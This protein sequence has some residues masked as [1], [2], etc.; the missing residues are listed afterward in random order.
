MFIYLVS[1]FGLMSAVLL[2]DDLKSLSG[3]EQPKQNEPSP[4]PELPPLPT[5]GDDKVIISQGRGL[6]LVGD[7]SN[8][9]YR[10]EIPPEGVAI[11]NLELPGPEDEL[12]QLLLPLFLDKPVTQQSIN[13]IK[14]AIILY[15]RKHDH[16]VMMVYVPEQKIRDGVL[17]L[18][19]IES[20]VGKL[21]VS[22]NRHARTDRIKR[23]I[24]LQPG[25]TI[26]EA[27]LL[28]DIT[29][30]NMNPFRSASIF[31]IPG[32]KTGT[33]DVNVRVIDRKPWRLYG[34]GDNSGSKHTGRAR[35]FTGFN[36]ENAF[37]PEN[38][39]SFQY[40]TSADFHKFNSYTIQY[41][42][43]F[44]WRHTLSVFAGYALVRPDMVGFTQ[45]LGRSYQASGRYEIPLWGTYPSLPQ[46]L[47]LGFDFKG[48]N[49][50]LIFGEDNL[51]RVRHTLVN[52]TQF[53]FGYHLNF[54]RW[55][56]K[57]ALG[58]EVL[59]SPGQLV[60]HESLSD[61]ESLNPHATPHYLYGRFFYTHNAPLP[62]RWSCFGQLR[63]QLSTQS[64]ISSEQF[65]F[66]GYNT[67]RGYP[68]RVVNGDNGVCINVEVRTPPVPFLSYFYSKIP[69]DSFFALVFYDYGHAWDHKQIPGLPLKQT[70]SSFGAG[71]RYNLSS[72]L[73][74]RLDIGY[75]L[76]KVQSVQEKV[77][78]DV[79][80]VL[81]Y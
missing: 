29:W 42:A 45:S 8:V 61:Y 37:F 70:L 51:E 65:G 73:N 55:R 72:Y 75:P 76:H 60:P 34:G 57:I 23:W 25:Q 1:F 43:P 44:S 30:I 62:Q 52:L 58:P 6:I 14:R 22:G 69:R 66:G 7:P 67:V 5:G 3:P 33:T 54:E 46:Q 74:A 13:Q 11:E 77:R 31:F 2:A 27:N 78:V 59:W 80:V 17:Q 24:R 56:Q 50:N 63:L 41:V 35:W 18:V 68:E 4:P 21:T 47:T 79:S 48:T 40:T 71:I 38:L 53:V 9:L 81:S 15:Y 39:F 20:K 19:V 36:L 49:N 12:R 16:P 64:L 26:N 10:S 28:R 32:E